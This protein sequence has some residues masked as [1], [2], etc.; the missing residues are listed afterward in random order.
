M[1]QCTGYLS[2]YLLIL[3]EEVCVV[4]LQAVAHSCLPVVGRPVPHTCKHLAL[5]VDAITDPEAS[6]CDNL[7]VQVEQVEG[8]AIEHSIR[9]LGAVDVPAPPVAEK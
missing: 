8:H 2:A 6:P 4:L 3:P 1:T 7:L 9:K 5:P